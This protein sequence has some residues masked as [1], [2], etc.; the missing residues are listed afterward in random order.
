MITFTN[1]IHINRSANDVYDYLCDL[2]HVPEWNWAIAETKKIS[3]GPINV[4]TRFRQT[5]TIPGPAIETLEITELEPDRHIEIQ[6]SLARLSARLTYDLDETGTGTELTNSMHLDASGALR[7]T[8]PVLGPRIK[9]A[10][11]D[12]LDELKT[13]LERSNPPSTGG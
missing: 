8:A 6:G 7:V 4:G 9:H 5:R 11:A 1:T 12:N 10:V 2:E 3:Q 13:R